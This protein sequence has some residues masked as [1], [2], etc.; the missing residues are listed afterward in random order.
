LLGLL[1]VLDLGMS[2]VLAREMA[3]ET[4]KARLGNLLRTFETIYCGIVLIAC[5][6]VFLGREFAS[7]HWLQ[8]STLSPDVVERSVVLM[9]CSAVLQVMMSLYLGAFLGSNRHVS[10]AAYQIGF[11]AVRSGVVIVPLFLTR[12]VEVFFWWQLAAAL[13]F[14]LLVRRNAWR[15]VGGP[16]GTRFSKHSFFNAS[17]FAAGMFGISLIA[18]INTQSDKLV[19]SSLFSLGQ[20][21]FYQICSLIGQTPAMLALPLAVTVLPQLTRLAAQGDIP[22]LQ[23]VYMRYSY[24]ISASAFVVAGAVCAGAPRIVGLMAGEDLA[25]VGDPSLAALLAIA[26]ACLAVQYMPYH[27]AVAYGHT[28]TNLIMGGVS[29]VCLPI[30]MVIGAEKFGFAGAA[31]PWLVMNLLAAFV[32]A[33]RLTPRFLGDVLPDWFLRTILLPMGIVAVVMTPAALLAPLV[34]P[35]ELFVVASAAGLAFAFCAVGY[36]WLGT[37]PARTSI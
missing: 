10:A 36:L 8:A 23:E 6:V 13:V 4:D 24:L 5:L 33:A 1:F 18:A 20:L 31:W 7:S 15:L 11:G 29:A 30:A 27:L 3:R 34:R 37:R 19:I 26:G 22:A 21:G 25:A 16:A 2:N 14:L 17:G 28:R 12:S 32:L 9:G 35:Y